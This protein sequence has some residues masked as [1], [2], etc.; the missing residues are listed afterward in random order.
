M[1][2]VAPDETVAEVAANPVATVAL[3]VLGDVLVPRVGPKDALLNDLEMDDLV[4]VSDTMEVIGPGVTGLLEVASILV[5]SLAPHRFD[6]AKD[7]PLEMARE[8][9][10]DEAVELLE[11][12]VTKVPTAVQEALRIRWP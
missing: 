1:V 10:L 5:A 12:V 6:L 9:P 8:R 7:D 2:V 3:Q 11:A 4:A